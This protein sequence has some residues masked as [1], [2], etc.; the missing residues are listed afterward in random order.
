MAE[1]KKLKIKKLEQARAA[2]INILEDTENARAE[3]EEEK[4]KTLAIITNFTDG[5]LVFNQ[6]SKLSLINPQGEKFL[7]LKQEKII[8]KSELEIAEIS[9]IKPLFKLL[10]KRDKEIFR[11][12]LLIRS[13][14]FAF[15][16]SA[17]SSVISFMASCTGEIVLKLSLIAIKTLNSSLMLVL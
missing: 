6:K 13:N 1:I 9:G 16:S 5:L 14:T 11:Q 2:L 8:G 10:K 4:N 15:R 3:A 7:N 17:I 12:E